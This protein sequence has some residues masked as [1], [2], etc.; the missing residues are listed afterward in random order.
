MRTIFF[1]WLT[2]HV[3]SSAFAQIDPTKRE[4]IQMGYNQ[5][6]QGRGPLAAYGFYYLNKP[7]VFEQ[8]N[9]T[10]RLA[11]APVYL[12]SELG[13]AHALGPNTDLG[14]G[15]AGGGFAD[16]YS[17]VHGGKYER[18]ESFIGHGGEV[19][20][21]IYHLFNPG[22]QIPLYALVR[23]ATHYSAFADDSETDDTFTLPEDQFTFRVRAGFR[24][25]GRAP[26]MQPDLAMEISAWYEG[27][28]RSKP[29]PYGYSGDREVEKNP[30]LFWGR[31]LL[32]YTL[33]E[34]KHN[35]GINVTAGTG[36]QLDR[37]S[38][39]RLGGNLPLY[40]EFPL[41]LPGYYFQELTARSFFLL[42]ANYSLPLD[43][44]Q[45]WR[46][47][48]LG[49]VAQIDY[50]DGLEQPGNLHS[51]VGGG[52]VY[53]SPSDSWQVAIAYGY[54]FQAIRDGGRGAHSLS[55][56]VQ[57]DLDN[58]RQR[59]FDP[60]ANINRSRGLQSIMRTIFR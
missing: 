37:L 36:T 56:L 45:R 17:E 13:L 23:G 33:P 42:G 21:S 18:R 14:I 59:F 6:L 32:A 24:W 8:T 26:L 11:V 20:A 34:L 46:L 40:S 12:D 49:S 38:A 55:I 4:L 44:N 5:P 2:L 3:I 54:G 28:F 39:Y 29:G 52:I 25:G 30:S 15:L 48:A 60:T 9:L 47:A 7:A 27:E 31:A 57:F 16:G 10:L 1:F 22:Q 19:S 43:A 50:L 51:G 58:T 41:S 35:F 53:R